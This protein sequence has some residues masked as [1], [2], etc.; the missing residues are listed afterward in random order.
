MNLLTWIPKLSSHR[1]SF[2]CKLEELIHLCRSSFYL[3]L[4]CIKMK[5]NYIVRFWPRSPLLQISAF[6][7]K[8]RSPAS[9]PFIRNSGYVGMKCF[10]NIRP[11]V[12]DLSIFLCARIIPRYLPENLITNNWL[13]KYR[14]KLIVWHKQDEELP[15]EVDEVISYCGDLKESCHPSC[16]RVLHKCCT[17]QYFQILDP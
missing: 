4:H 14:Y 11:I 3:E 13:I 2:S 12:V 5:Q 10:L 16:C 8:F 17:D 15:C 9:S 1:Q 6:F 7:L